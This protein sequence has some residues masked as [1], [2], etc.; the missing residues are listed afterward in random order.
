MTTVIPLRTI[1]DIAA[2]PQIG[3][4]IL[5]ALGAYATVGAIVAKPGEDSTTKDTKHTKKSGRSWMPSS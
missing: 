3:A 1:L 5:P 2:L 4:C